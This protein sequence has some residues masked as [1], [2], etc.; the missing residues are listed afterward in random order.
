MIRSISVQAVR[1]ISFLLMAGNAL[2]APLIL[3]FLPYIY[4]AWSS[5]TGGENWAS[6]LL[7]VCIFSQFHVSLISLII[8]LYSLKRAAYL[9]CLFVSIIPCVNLLFIFL[10][11]LYI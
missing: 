5:G 7:L 4:M 3:S 2:L 10:A 11:W 9:D 6:W 8:Y 1:R